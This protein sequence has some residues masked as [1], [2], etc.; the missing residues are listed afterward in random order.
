MH[1][2]VQIVDVEPDNAFS[3]GLPTVDGLFKIIQDAI[4]DK[5][6]GLTVAYDAELGYPTNVFIDSV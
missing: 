4:N 1:F 5:V 6:D 2:V 3:D